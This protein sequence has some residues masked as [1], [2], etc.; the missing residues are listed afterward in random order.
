LHTVT[1]EDKK[2]GEQAL[3]DGVLTAAL[4]LLAAKNFL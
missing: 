1:N 4:Q 2:S 3:L